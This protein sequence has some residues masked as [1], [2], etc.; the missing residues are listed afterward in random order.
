MLFAFFVLVVDVAFF[1]LVVDV[2][3]F[4]AFVTMTITFRE[5]DRG[6][7]VDRVV[8]R[9]AVVFSGFN[10]VPKAF[11]EERSVDNERIGVADERYLLSRSLE[12]VRI[13]A[14][15]HDDLDVGEITNEVFD[16]VAQDVGR[17]GDGRRVLGHASDRYLGL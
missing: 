3:L 13:G 11:F 17:Y 1:V 16:H 4:L 12:V 15:R 8:H 5:F 7:S 6:N 14:Y 10:H 2:A 9:N